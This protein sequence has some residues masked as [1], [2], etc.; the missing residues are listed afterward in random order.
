[1]DR[2]F[3]RAIKSPRRPP[4][5][6]VVVN[7]FALFC[8]R[9]KEVV[10]NLILLPILVSVLGVGLFSIPALIGG[11]MMF[12]RTTASLGK[13]ILVYTFCSLLLGLVFCWIGFALMLF[14]FFTGRTDPPFFIVWAGGSFGIVLGAILAHRY[15]L[16]EQ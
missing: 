6:S 3:R 14:E 13:R 11:A 7:T 16:G 12:S 2:D 8:R 5:L 4:R 9:R 1:M 10:V 15:L